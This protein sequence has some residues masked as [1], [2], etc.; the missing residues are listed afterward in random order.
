MGCCF[1]AYAD[2][3]VPNTID[4]CV[5][6]QRISKMTLGRWFPYDSTTVLAQPGNPAN[7][8]DL[9]YNA[10]KG[11]WQRVE[12]MFR[13]TS[14]ATQ[15]EV[16]VP[17][18][19]GHEWDRKYAHWLNGSVLDFS[20]PYKICGREEVLAAVVTVLPALPQVKKTCFV[21]LSTGMLFLVSDKGLGQRRRFHIF[22]LSELSASPAGEHWEVKF[23]FKD[24]AETV[25]LQAMPP[26]PKSEELQLVLTSTQATE[27]IK[28][29]RRLAA[30]YSFSPLKTDV[31]EALLSKVTLPPMPCDGGFMSYFYSALMY[32]GGA[33]GP[34]NF[35]Q[36]FFAALPLLELNVSALDLNVNRTIAVAVRIGMSR[37]KSLRSFVCRGSEGTS[38]RKFTKEIFAELLAAFKQGRGTL[39]KLDLAWCRLEP[40]EIDQLLDA[41]CTP[42]GRCATAHLDLSGN[43]LY[44][45][46]DRLASLIKAVPGG[47]RKLILA[48]CELHTNSA[49]QV[50]AAIA[51]CTKLEHL[52][53]ANNQINQLDPHPLGN[54]WKS[55]KM[56]VLNL[57]NTR[58]NIEKVLETAAPSQLTKLRE[59]NLAGCAFPAEQAVVTK[60]FSHL[61]ASLEKVSIQGF[62]KTNE[63]KMAMFNA[64]MAKPSP[65]LVYTLDL[66]NFEMLTTELIEPFMRLEKPFTAAGLTIGVTTCAADAS[67]LYHQMLSITAEKWKAAFDKGLTGSAANAEVWKA[68]AAS[69]RGKAHLPAITACQKLAEVFQRLAVTQLR[70]LAQ[71]QKKPQNADLRCVIASGQI[72]EEFRISIDQ[73][74]FGPATALAVEGLSLN[75]QVWQL[76]MSNA[77]GGD[78]LAMAL[79]SMLKSNRTLQSL[80]VGGNYFTPFGWGAIRGALYGNKKLLE[81]QFP[82]KDVENMTAAYQT[83]LERMERKVLQCR[84]RIKSA[85]KSTKGRKTPHVME[86]QEREVKNII[87]IKVSMSKAR[88]AMQ[89]L[90]DVH[91]QIRQAIERNQMEQKSLE[92][93]KKQNEKASRFGWSA[94]AR[95]YQKMEGLMVKKQALSKEA[96]QATIWQKRN[97]LATAW[98]AKKAALEKKGKDVKWLDGWIKAQTK[99]DADKSIVITHQ[100]AS[101]LLMSIPSSLSGDVRTEIKMTRDFIKLDEEYDAKQQQLNTELAE[102]KL[103]IAEVQSTPNYVPPTYT[104]DWLGRAKGLTKEQVNQLQGTKLANVAPPPL[105][106]QARVVGV[107]EPVEGNVVQG[108][109]VEPSP[110]IQQAQ[111]EQFELYQRQQQQMKRKLDQQRNYNSYNYDAYGYDPSFYAYMGLWQYQ[112]H[113]QH[114][115]YGYHHQD[116]YY[117]DDHFDTAPYDYGECQFAQEFGASQCED[118]WTGLPDDPPEG[119]EGVGAENLEEAAEAVEMYA[120][121]E[122]D[123]PE[124]GPHNGSWKTAC[125]APPLDLSEWFEEHIARAEEDAKSAVLGRL[126][127]L[128]YRR[129]VLLRTRSNQRVGPGLCLVTQCSLD[130]LGRLR[131]Q[132]CGWAGEV[133]AAVFVDHMQ[134]SEAAAT[135]RRGIREM[136]FEAAQQFGG[137]VPAW[138]IVVLYRLEDEHVKCEAYDRLYPVNA[139][140]NAALEHARSELLFLVDV[141]FVPSRRL[142]EVL[143]GDDGGRRLLNALSHGSRK[144]RGP[145]ALV[146]PAFEAAKSNM[147]LPLHG[148]EL[149][150]AVARGEVEG[151]HVSHFPCGH[152]ATDFDRWL[153]ASKAESPDAGNFNQHAHGVDAYLIH[154][155]EH[156][157]PYVVVPR[158]SVPAY[159]ERF[160]GYGLNKI[161]HLYELSQRGFRFR[162][163]AHAEAFVVAAKHPKSQS[164]HLVLGP[165]AEAEQRARIA[166][167]YA[168]FKAELKQRLRL[169]PTKPAKAR[170]T[171]RRWLPMKR[172]ASGSASS[173]LLRTP[174]DAPAPL[175]VAV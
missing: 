90:K 14:S 156:F 36:E 44:Q 35:G 59:L 25:N 166:T 85:Y 149:R 16:L 19:P 140:R 74:G 40:E 86:T 99:D 116:H 33:K 148:A 146:I 92:A 46:K 51:T 131:D 69:F 57:M 170:T 103:I 73:V 154:Y 113:H 45:N 87:E 21:A 67:N 77:L 24:W 28:E 129:Q 115:Y 98:L 1:T 126:G 29:V 109:V 61:G 30:V 12:L 96:D 3:D 39:L 171:P 174:L 76:D 47:M 157:E 151:F 20:F 163:C 121:G 175:A 91:E 54:I 117:H 41:L 142:H 123:R 17:G 153:G 8:A 2:Q 5:Y 145:G 93:R 11:T 79:G 132:L 52:N 9:N 22:D 89:K 60:F 155:E 58:T 80:Q 160:R 15:T 173:S 144:N 102:Q 135:A 83:E 10:K 130:R 27:L 104:T 100:S 64:L 63:E 125:P 71:A 164:W 53:L 88:Q 78:A 159:D 106:V 49:P 165:E 133:S 94:A 81:L 42:A 31:P 48:D 120:G 43:N 162:T 167:H 32:F 147:P 112:W 50:F 111:Y 152:R 161:S 13:F 172:L 169:S 75:K 143:A 68:V 55:K 95:A 114:Y 62:G 108:I 124:R 37:A 134:D 4:Q 23:T 119:V 84:S 158:Q 122:D 70:F 26:S 168:T 72:G 118:Y 65:A 18:G 56:E 7:P 128:P 101:A 82:V 138:T 105:V 107:G 34:I 137:N 139:L 38:Q 6:G 110:A 127:R 66:D 136:C 97:A 150:H 141:D